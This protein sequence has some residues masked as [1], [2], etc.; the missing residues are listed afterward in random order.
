MLPRCSCRPKITVETATVT[1]CS[2]TTTSGKGQNDM[3]SCA[4]A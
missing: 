2:V 1:G 3:K 4:G